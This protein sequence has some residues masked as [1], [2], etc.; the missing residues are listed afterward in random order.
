MKIVSFYLEDN[1]MTHPVL[2]KLHIYFR[3]LRFWVNTFE[4]CHAVVLAEIKAQPKVTPKRLLLG[5]FAIYL[6]AVVIVQLGGLVGLWTAPG[7]LEASPGQGLVDEDLFV[8]IFITT[9]GT[10]LGV[11]A[12]TATFFMSTLLKTKLLTLKLL[13]IGTKKTA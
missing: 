12:I 11:M 9:L 3:L 6:V 1:Q 5:W 7:F 13:N 2:H 4:S 8:T 10:I